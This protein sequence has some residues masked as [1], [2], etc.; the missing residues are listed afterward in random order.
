MM[1]LF[2][3]ILGGKLSILG[4]KVHPC[5]PPTPHYMKPCVPIITGM[6]I[7]DVYIMCWMSIMKYQ[8]EFMTQILKVISCYLL[9][10]VKRRF[11]LCIKSLLDTMYD[12]TEVITSAW[13]WSLMTM[14]LTLSS[15]LT[16]EIKV[17]DA[18]DTLSTILAISTWSACC[19]SKQDINTQVHPSSLHVHAPSR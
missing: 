13:M 19:N 3:T 1:S 11:H 8:P 5:P 10:R 18:I 12:W 7:C 17:V 15:R 16:N 14:F 6:H 9:D 4:G 2:Y